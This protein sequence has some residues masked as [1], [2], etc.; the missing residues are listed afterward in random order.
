PADIYV[1][2][3]R[4]TVF[5]I[6]GAD[7][8]GHPVALTAEDVPAG[9]SFADH[10][11]GTGTLTVTWAMTQTGVIP[12]SFS[13]ANGL[14]AQ[15]WATTWLHVYPTTASAPPVEAGELQLAVDGP[16]PTRPPLSVTF[17]LPEHQAARI[18]LVDV[19][20]RIVVSREVGEFAPGSHR[21]TLAESGTL[22]P[23]FYLVRL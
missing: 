4:D 9:C 21:L 6:R 15:A 19:G 14:G 10:G 8:R 13:C 20:G 1:M 17:T 7:T 2:A 23:G 18:D 3:H 11:D 5:S 16:N 22:R 12:I